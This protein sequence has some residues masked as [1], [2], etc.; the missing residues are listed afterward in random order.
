MFHLF[1]KVLQLTKNKNTRHRFKYLH[2]LDSLSILGLVCVP[3]E[4][5]RKAFSKG[6]TGL[7]EALCKVKKTVSADIKPEI[8]FILPCE[9]HKAIN[10]I[11]KSIGEKPHIITFDEFAKVVEKRGSLGKRFAK[12]LRC[13]AKYPAGS[14]RPG[15]KCP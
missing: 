6:G 5:Y 11:E 7:S 1:Q 12:S 15:T 2:I 10:K 4:V 13:W 3:G 14:V 8:V 9:D